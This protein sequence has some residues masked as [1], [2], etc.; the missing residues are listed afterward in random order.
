MINLVY[1]VRVIFT[2]KYIGP[3]SAKIIPNGILLCLSHRPHPAWLGK[4]HV[5]MLQGLLNLVIGR[6]DFDD[7][8]SSSDARVGRS[9]RIPILNWHVLDDTVDHI[10]TRAK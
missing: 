10:R 7:R 9:K 5:Q 3:R 6:H 2:V 8:D 1:K 4:L